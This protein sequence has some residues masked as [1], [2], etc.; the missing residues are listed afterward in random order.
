MQDRDGSKEKSTWSLCGSSITSTSADT[1]STNYTGVLMSA[2]CPNSRCRRPFKNWKAVTS[3]LNSAE[4]TCFC[5]LSEA[6]RPTTGLPPVP[7]PNKHPAPIINPEDTE[8]S[9]ESIN[10][11]LD[12][13]SPPSA[14]PS[15]SFSPEPVWTTDTEYHPTSSYIVD[16][17]G[18]NILQ[19]IQDDQYAYRRINNYF[20]PFKDREE[21]ELARF[22]CSSSLNQGDIDVFLKLPWVSFYYTYCKFY[23]TN[24]IRPVK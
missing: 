4:S 9:D 1:L 11:P 16:Q 7:P 5:C 6:D 21:W 10:I 3:H 15:Q 13:Y 18:K 14:S 24:I 19:R 23:V 12:N 8:M 22:L 2:I 17:N 20:Y